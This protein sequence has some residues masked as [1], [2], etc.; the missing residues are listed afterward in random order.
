ME[1]L[2]PPSDTAGSYR[3]Q[4]LNPGLLSG[5]SLLFSP[6]NLNHF[7]VWNLRL[8]IRILLSGEHDE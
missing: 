3:S 6:H 1:G 7:L 8:R 4:D 5:K 2:C